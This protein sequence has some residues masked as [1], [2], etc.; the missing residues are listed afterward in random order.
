MNLRSMK[1]TRSSGLE[2]LK[3]T[4]EFWVLDIQDLHHASKLAGTSGSDNR[5]DPENP[6]AAG[7]QVAYIPALLVENGPA[8]GRSEEPNTT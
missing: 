8:H 1:N 6:A 3:G 4:L 7:M 2:V 5:G